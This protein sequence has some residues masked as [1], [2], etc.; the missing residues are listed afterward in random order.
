MKVMAIA[1]NAFKEAV[2]DRILYTILAFALGMI[3]SSVI[4][5]TLSVGGEIKIIKDLGLASISLFGTLIAIFIG[6]GLVYKE[7]ERRTIYTI[8]AKPI[9]RY[10]FIL[11]KYLGLLITLFVNLFIM[12][13]VLFFLTYLIERRWSWEMLPALLLT[14]VELMVITAVSI[15]F[16]TFTTPTLSAIFTLSIFIIGRFSQD[17]K[18]FADQ[19]GGPALQ[20]AA[21]TLYSLLP[22]LSNFNIRGQ[23]VHG[24]PVPPAFLWFSMFYGLFYLSALLASAALIFQQRDFK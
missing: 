12:A 10:E 16:S 15:L 11:G 22:N 21:F 1:L 5:A 8:I 14:F 4:L 2:R 3:L 23:V 18:T 17:L 20:A 13:L 24:I 7:I 9:H 6:V 19:F